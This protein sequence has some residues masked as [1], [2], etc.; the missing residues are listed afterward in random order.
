MAISAWHDAIA[1]VNNSSAIQTVGTPA[2]SE[3]TVIYG[4]VADETVFKTGE[5]VD[6]I[7][8]YVDNDSNISSYLFASNKL[9]I[10]ASPSNVIDNFYR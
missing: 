4:L 3:L 6:P 8:I 9:K 5:V 7:G 2:S 10:Q 1:G